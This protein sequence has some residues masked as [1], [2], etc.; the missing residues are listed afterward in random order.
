MART[1]DAGLRSELGG[2]QTAFGW[3]LADLIRSGE[4]NP[5]SQV[6][7]YAGDAETYEVFRPLLDP[8]I[9][10]CHP[11]PGVHVRE[12]ADPADFDDLDPSGEHVRS[13]RVR[14]AR[15]VA[16]HRFP[17][18]MDGAHHEAL[19][20]Q[21][22][23]AFAALGGGA[24]RPLEAMTPEARRAL[25][26]EHVLFRD[27]DRFLE[28]A[29][30]YRDFPRGRA[31]YRADD[32]RLSAWV[33]EE[34]HLRLFALVPGGDLRLALT[35]LRDALDALGAQVDFAFD[36]RLG[37]LA[38]CPTNLGTAMRA[39]VHV[40]LPQLAGDRPRLEALAQEHGLQVRGTHGEHSEAED[41]VFDLSNAHRLGF[42]EA[43]LLRRLRD[44]VAAVL[45][46]ERASA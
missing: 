4:R 41:A 3:T 23:P 29:G 5:D 38:S 7:L 1:L 33:G 30:V 35:R 20:E 26:Q 13:T 2:R 34:D 18:A 27:D 11:G 36:D 19:R 12:P 40:R 24:L 21:V 32:G 46:A 22:R 15:N 6:G 42:S 37:H 45:A 14:V 17:P 31:L 16:G 39:S 9:A 8:I 10:G 44:G 25:V 28:A 43:E